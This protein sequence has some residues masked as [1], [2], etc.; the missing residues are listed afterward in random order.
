M[1]SFKPEKD[2]LLHEGKVVQK[3]SRLDRIFSWIDTRRG[4]SSQFEIGLIERIWFKGN[5]LDIEL[6]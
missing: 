5:P 2:K 6:D 4:K 3:G 1:I